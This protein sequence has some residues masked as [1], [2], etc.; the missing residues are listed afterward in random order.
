MTSGP[1]VRAAVEGTSD[2]G[3]ARRLVTHCGLAVADGAQ[4]V[5][6]KHGS[7]NL[8][9][10]ATRLARGAS[11]H[12]PWIVL[13]DAD[14]Q[15][16]VTLA[17]C[18]LPQSPGDGFLLRI[19]V[20]EMEAW[21][22]AD[23]NGVAK[24]FSMSTANLP[25]DLDELPDAKRTLVQM[26]RR[27]R[28]RD[29]RGAMTRPQDDRPGPEYTTRVTRFAEGRWDVDAARSRSASLDRAVQALS[30]FRERLTVP[31]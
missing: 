7:G 4:G 25:Q 9:K 21:L 24:E 26:C 18:L 22:L 2:V 27:S 6:V 19:A 30:R 8:D 29:V 16:P 10:L 1:W 14:R 12:D 17:E 11:L 5:L 20:A 28:S 31:G 23:V 13:R 3:L 15:C